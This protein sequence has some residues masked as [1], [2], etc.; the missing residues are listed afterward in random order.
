M[1]SHRIL[2]GTN[3]KMNKTRQE[4]SDYTS[5]LLELLESTRAIERAQV[6][7]IPPFT[8]IHAVKRASRGK[9]WTGAQNM[10]WA[11][12]GA[13]TGEISAPM[14]IDLGADLVE[15]G[16]A[17]RRRYFNE[18]DSEINRKVQSALRYAL[19]P[20]I[21][22]GESA[23]DKEFGV[24]R[25]TLSRQIKI[26]LCG[27]EPM[28]AARLIIAY[29]PVWAIGRD[30]ASAT[31]GHVRSMRELI[32]AVLGE[33]FGPGISTCVP[34]IYGGDVNAGNCAA[35]LKEGRVDGLFVGRA[36]CQADAFA[37][38]IRLA[39]EAVA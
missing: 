13:Y 9:L 35:L 33:I 21:C 24:G 31:P 16:H 29:E 32:R 22:V 2:F 3:W 36:G 27:V 17:E 20:L 23:E 15:L 4:A 28:Q 30:S 5:R 14:L 37:N 11:D 8:A 10:H 1:N 6:F 7:V 34:V 18:T 12:W 19:R 38:L 25:E 39:L 26:A